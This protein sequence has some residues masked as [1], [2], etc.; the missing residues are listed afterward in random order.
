MP[1]EPALAPSSC[2][3]CCQ[4]VLLVGDAPLGHHELEHLG[5]VL[6][7]GVLD[8]VIDVVPAGGLM[9]GFV[10]PVS[11]SSVFQPLAHMEL[12]QPGNNFS[13]YTYS[14]RGMNIGAQGLG[15]RVEG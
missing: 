15:I 13:T 10:P 6:G 9:Q 12:H 11:S 7:E 3:I 5:H 14:R 8:V 4:G 2:E 1:A